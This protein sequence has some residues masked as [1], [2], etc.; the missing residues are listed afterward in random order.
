MKPDARDE[1]SSRFMSVLSVYEHE[2]SALE[3][4]LALVSLQ[5]NEFSRDLMAA[6][7]SDAGARKRHHDAS[8]EAATAQRLPRARPPGATR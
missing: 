2:A 3:D 4:R 6:I 5:M 8:V 7:E 1:T